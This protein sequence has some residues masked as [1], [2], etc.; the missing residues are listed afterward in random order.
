M[1]GVIDL[2]SA[3]G[4]TLHLH[5]LRS[6][7]RPIPSAACECGPCVEQRQRIQQRENGGLLHPKISKKYVY[8]ALARS[9]H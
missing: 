3:G 5:T 2:R 6:P 9:F 4:A 7:G 8:D 1:S